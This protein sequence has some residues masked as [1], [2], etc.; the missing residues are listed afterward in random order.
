MRHLPTCLLVPLLL[1]L[2][3]FAAR[4]GVAP[5][6]G[7]GLT[8]E[9]AR[10]ARSLL[11]SE[12]QEQRPEDLVTSIALAEGSTVIQLLEESRIQGAEELVIIGVEQIGTK[13]IIQ[14]RLFDVA[15]EKGLYSDS[16]PL[17]AI[18][19]LDMAMERC[20]E[21]LARRKPLADLA[22]VG[23]VMENEG[24][25][26]RERRALSR[27]TFQ[28]GYMWPLED[29]FDGHKRRFTGAWSTG[30]EE[31]NFDAGFEFSWREGPAALLYTDWLMRPADL[32]PFLGVAGG[33]HWARHRELVEDGD[34]LSGNFDLDDGFHVALR[35]GVI[36]LRTYGF[37]MV[38]QA[39]YA[40]TFNDNDDRCWMLTL[41][42]RP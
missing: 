6:E 20:A 28:V 34:P 39:E 33:F 12:L 19:D 2:M 26:T 38:V 22:R 40:R 11:V 21:A 14:V 13:R 29:T 9:E 1:P 41:G 37:Q 31:R 27:T 7:G 35:G 32:C 4:I 16:M 10:V 5:V 18:E 3:L 42:M 8:G 24:L 36:L 30:L 15:T 25:N 17:A 23:D